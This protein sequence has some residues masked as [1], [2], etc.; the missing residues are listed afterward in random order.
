MAAT[1]QLVG[2]RWALLVIR[3]LLFD[4]H[5]FDALARNI[6]APRDRLSARLRDLEAAGVIERRQYQERPVRSEYHLTEAG[7][8]LA[9]VVQTLMAWG[10]KWAVEEPPVVLRHTCDHKFAASVRCAHCGETARTSDLVFES[11]VAGWDVHGPTDRDEPKRAP[12]TAA[13][14]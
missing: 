8:E 13:S 4:N 11:R 9:P 3:E 7:R 1:L 10:D 14:K 2:D 5:R 12:V 6:G